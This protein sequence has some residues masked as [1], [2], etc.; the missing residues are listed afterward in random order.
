MKINVD[1]TN[2]NA[3]WVKRTP[4]TLDALQGQDEFQALWQSYVALARP[5]QQRYARLSRYAWD[6][7]KHPRGKPENSGQFAPKGEAVKTPK[8]KTTS[9]PK[10]TSPKSEAFQ[11]H[12]DI[13]NNLHAKDEAGWNLDADI[14]W[15]GEAASIVADA[16]KESVKRRIEDPNAADPIAHDARRWAKEHNASVPIEQ[17]RMRVHLYHK[18]A[19]HVIRKFNKRAT[20]RVNHFLQK[21]RYFAS[22]G[23]LT[24]SLDRHNKVKGP[25]TAGCFMFSRG[26]DARDGELWIDGGGDMGDQ[27]PWLTKHIYSHELSHAV[28]GCGRWRLSQTKAWKKI[29]AE[30]IA[31]RAS[32]GTPAL[33]EPHQKP[34]KV[35]G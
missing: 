10:S 6:E 9:K 7:T 12:P 32:K 26:E 33:D 18:V 8:K 13:H 31:K 2:T 30:D 21:I 23:Q 11:N 14:D 35:L 28:D 16:I 4:D 34:E 29:W 25:T 19:R 22:T 24:D 17:L 5:E 20:A 1:S 27:F 15:H 3:D